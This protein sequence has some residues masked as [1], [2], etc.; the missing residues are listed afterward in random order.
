MSKMTNKSKK[1]DKFFQDL[2]KDAHYSSGTKSGMFA[3]YRRLRDD[4]IQQALK[5]EREKVVERLE[6]LMDKKRAKEM[7]D[8]FELLVGKRECHVCG[9]NFEKQRKL[10][11][12]SLKNKRCINMTNKSEN[13]LREIRDSLLL[14]L[15]VL[16]ALTGND[17]QK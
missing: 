4:F 16:C 2:L 7:G 14:M 17:K 13:T 10:I 3:E 1:I 12:N 5:Q 6:I 15:A 11:L 8:N 9:T